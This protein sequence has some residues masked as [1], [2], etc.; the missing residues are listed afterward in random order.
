MDRLTITQRLK[1]IKTYYKNGD[2]GLHRPT[3]QAI[4]TIVK[5][6]E[7]TAVVT[8]IE[9]PVINRFAR[10]A[11]NIAIVSESVAEDPNM[12]IPLIF[13]ELVLLTAHYSVF[14]I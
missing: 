10:S 6:F 9:R 8:N 1:I 13:Q 14:C 5:K 2:S 4:G 3:M 7:E 12:S 11:V